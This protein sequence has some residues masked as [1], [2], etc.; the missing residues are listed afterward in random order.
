MAASAFVC[1]SKKGRAR[2]GVAVLSAE[3][4]DVRLPRSK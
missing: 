4:L 3:K 2:M 1:V